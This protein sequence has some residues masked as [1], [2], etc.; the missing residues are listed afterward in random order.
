MENQE[1]EIRNAK[2]CGYCRIKVMCRLSRTVMPSMR[3]CLLSVRLNKVLVSSVCWCR[4]SDSS[5]VV[6]VCQADCYGI[7]R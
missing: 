7:E 1:M 6:G 3:R 5:I 2:A 4:C